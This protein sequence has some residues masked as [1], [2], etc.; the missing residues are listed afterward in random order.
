MDSMLTYTLIIAIRTSYPAMKSV[1]NRFSQTLDPLEADNHI[2]S[3]RE[4]LKLI[5]GTE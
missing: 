3:I 2:I 5:P 4:I 1:A